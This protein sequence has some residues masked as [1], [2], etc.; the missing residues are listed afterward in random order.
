LTKSKRDRGKRRKMG[1]QTWKQLRVLM[2][3][4]ALIS[5]EGISSAE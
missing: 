4:V 2:D 3:E 1:M 5:A